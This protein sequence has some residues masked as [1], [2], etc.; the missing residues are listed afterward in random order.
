MKK[1]FFLVGV[2][3]I[4]TFLLILGVSSVAVAD[5][6]GQVGSTIDKVSDVKDTLS[7]EDARSEYLKQEWNKIL[8]NNAFGRFVLGISGVFVALSPLFKLFIGVEYS[9]SWMFFL[10]LAFWIAAFFIIFYAAKLVFND[11]FLICFLIAIIIPA[12]AAQTKIFPNIVSLFIPLFT[13]SKVIILSILLIVFILLVY[14]YFMRRLAKSL[15]QRDKKE[16]EKI[17]EGKAK[18][19]EKIHDMEIKS[20]G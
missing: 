2:L 3:L 5:S 1:R 16:R 12:I 7:D 4:F 15:E 13:N 19:V 6:L 18:L 11:K 17:R 14:I 20:R 9:L 10:S 8:E